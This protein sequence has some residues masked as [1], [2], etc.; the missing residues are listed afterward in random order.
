M[1]NGEENG[2]IRAFFARA[3]EKGRQIFPG[4]KARTKDTVEVQMYESDY[5]TLIAI[6]I[7]LL[8]IQTFIMNPF[9]IQQLRTGEETEDRYQIQFISYI[10]DNENGRFDEE[11][12]DLNDDGDFLDPGEYPPD[13]VVDDPD[14]APE[15]TN[16]STTIKKQEL[17]RDTGILAG[18]VVFVPLL[19][20][21]FLLFLV[22]ENDSPLKVAFWVAVGFA[23]PIIIYAIL[24]F[25]LT[26]LYNLAFAFG[27]AAVDI[28]SGAAATAGDWV[29]GGINTMSNTAYGE[30][31]IE[32]DGASNS[33]DNAGNDSS[34]EASSFLDS[35]WV[36]L[37][38]TTAAIFFSI[39][40]IFVMLFAI[41]IGVGGEESYIVRLSRGW[42]YGMAVA[43][44][45]VFGVFTL[46]GIG[47]IVGV[48]G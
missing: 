3:G 7:F 5:K 42:I 6:G 1:P 24:L 27:G 15:G 9:V 20:V 11:G 23:A 22:G 45:M 36:M 25:I 39:F 41:S 19:Y 18:S 12:K 29:I 32:T 13:E 30:D 33:L 48:A 35:Q 47:A 37:E 2:G 17:Q 14:D 43:L 40:T 31:L 21:I 38:E 34:N 26:L 10:D 28:A 8:A 46:L 44:L 16:V 4:K